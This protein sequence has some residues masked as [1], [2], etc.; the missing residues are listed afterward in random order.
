MIAILKYI[1]SFISNQSIHPSN[2]SINPIS[3]SI[4]PINQSI[5]SVNQSIQSINQSIQ[6]ISQSIQSV[7][8]SIQSVNQ[9]I[10]SV[11]HPLIYS[12]QRIYV[13]N[14]IYVFFATDQ[15]SA[16]SVRLNCSQRAIWRSRHLHVLNWGDEYDWW[17][18]VQPLGCG[19]C[20]WCDEN[21]LVLWTKYDWWLHRP[22]DFRYV[23]VG[24]ATC[25]VVSV[26]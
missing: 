10:Q 20:T 18:V 9:S 19:M 6:S 21:A 5:Q 23:A 7:N 14:Y 25:E 22:R 4:H 2:Q 26:E 15:P 3:Q 11:N 16:S 24:S 13:Y 8:Q 1:A 17:L 12:I